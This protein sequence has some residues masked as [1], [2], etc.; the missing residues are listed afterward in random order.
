MY[1]HIGHL[2]AVG[3][4]ALHVQESSTVV[5]WTA[6]FSFDVTDNSPDITYCVTVYRWF[7][8]G[9]SV[10]VCNLTTTQYTVVSEESNPCGRFDITVTPVNGVGEGVSVTR[11][12]YIF[13]SDDSCVAMSRDSTGGLR[14]AVGKDYPQPT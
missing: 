9:E 5:N 7:D 2:S 11:A 4:L 3:D 12:G 10:L 6:P 1:I 13:T 8:G 14:A